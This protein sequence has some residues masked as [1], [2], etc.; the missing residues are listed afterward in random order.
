MI[1]PKDSFPNMERLVLYRT[2]Q[3]LEWASKAVTANVFPNL[4]HLT[5]HTAEYELDLQSGIPT[6]VHDHLLLE[7]LSANSISYTRCM[8]ENIDLISKMSHLQALDIS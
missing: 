8:L 7:S 2:A 4:K 1:F 3:N 6:Y 5:L